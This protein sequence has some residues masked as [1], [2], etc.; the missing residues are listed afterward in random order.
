M[1]HNLGAIRQLCKKA[2]VLRNGKMAFFGD[3]SEAIA[4]YTKAVSENIDGNID[5]RKFIG[6]LAGK[7]I[8]S[9]V[10]VNGEQG[11]AAIPPSSPLTIRMEGDSKDSFDQFSISA[12]IFS[13]GVR[14]I[15]VMDGAK[16]SP[17]PTGGFSSTIVIPPYTLRPGEYSIGVGG[18]NERG[19]W[20]FGEEILRFSILKEWDEKNRKSETGL[21]NVSYQGRRE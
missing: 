13:E 3:T 1:S 20:L 14:V 18:D 9:K 6:Q 16:P 4:H 10:T 8:F 2:I 15:T 7:V 17:L 19:E 11:L 12:A 5:P 21:V